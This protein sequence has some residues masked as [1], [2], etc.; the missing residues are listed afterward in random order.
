[1]VRRDVESLGIQLQREVKDL[2]EADRRLAL[3]LFRAVRH[4]QH[5]EWMGGHLPEYL[6][7][8]VEKWAAA[9][10][11][12]W[13]TDPETVT[14]SV[15]FHEKHHGLKRHRFGDNAYDAAARELG[16]SVSTVIKKTRRKKP[17][18]SDDPEKE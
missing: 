6:V 11:E 4:V 13:R 10:D 14:R 12:R 18:S 2:A 16:I 9:V 1:M 7:R 5:P 8:A 3:Q 17:V 15:E